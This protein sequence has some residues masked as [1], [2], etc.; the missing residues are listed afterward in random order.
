M[1]SYNLKNPSQ[2]KCQIPDL[3]KIYMDYFGFKRNGYYVEVGGFDGISWSNTFGLAVAGWNGL[4]LEPQPIFYEECIKNYDFLPNVKILKTCAGD[5]QG[6]IELFTGYSLATTKKEMVDTYNEIDWF[7]G[8]V[9]KNNSI[10]S[11]IDTLNNILQTNQFP[12]NFDLLVID[13]QGAELDVIKGIDL[14]IWKPQ[15]IIIELHEDNQYD[16][17]KTNNKEIIEILERG[18]YKKIFKD[19]NNSIFVQEKDNGSEI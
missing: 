11:Q 18:N 16:S 12:K 14:N 4:I 3:D 2:H 6:E 17:L 10:I 5:Y 7:K 9:N 15:M 8:I 13:V 19:E 1:K